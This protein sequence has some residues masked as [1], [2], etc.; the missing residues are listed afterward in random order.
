[1]PTYEYLCKQCG[2]KLEAFQ[3]ITARPLTRCPECGRKRL[4]RVLGAGAGIIFK[5]SGFY[6]TDYGRNSRAP[7]QTGSES[8]ASKPKSSSSTSESPASGGDASA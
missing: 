5:G 3:S 6:A 2:H 8:T 7:S 4:Q 1:M